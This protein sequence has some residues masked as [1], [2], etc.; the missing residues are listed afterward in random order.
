MLGEGLDGAVQAA[1]RTWRRLRPWFAPG[2]APALW[3]HFVAQ[4]DY[5]AFS[6]KCLI[7]QVPHPAACAS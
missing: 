5:L 7:T 3:A 6:R 4:D 1:E 2:H